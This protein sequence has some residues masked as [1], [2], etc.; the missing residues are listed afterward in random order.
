M[1][2]AHAQRLTAPEMTTERAYLCALTAALLET[3]GPKKAPRLLGAMRAQL[4]DAVSRSEAIPIRADRE[5]YARERE[6]KLAAASAFMAD[7][8]RLLR[9]ASE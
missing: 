5:R 7:L 4:A 2:E 3:L 1:S 6:A 8:P 9:A